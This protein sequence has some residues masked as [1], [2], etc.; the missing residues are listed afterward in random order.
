MRAAADRLGLDFL[1]VGWETYYLAASRT[2]TAP[3]FEALIAAVRAR[4]AGTPEPMTL[5]GEALLSLL[6]LHRP[7]E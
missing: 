1:S 5:V 7:K 3:A 2:L 4:A 6:N